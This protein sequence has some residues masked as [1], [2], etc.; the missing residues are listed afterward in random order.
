MV[1]NWFRENGKPS[2]VVFADRFV[3]RP[4]AIDSPVNII[5]AGDGPW[6]SIIL[7][8]VISQRTLENFLQGHITYIVF[9][10]RLGEPGLSKAWLWY[11]Q[12]EA[13]VPASSRKRAYPARMLCLDWANAVFATTD[14]EV[15]EVNH[16]QLAKDLANRTDGLIPGCLERGVT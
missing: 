8:P 9:D 14:Y 6:K 13:S 7:A 10:R 11:T 16:S 3:S 1:A 4:I 2:D 12:Y 5:K 15:L